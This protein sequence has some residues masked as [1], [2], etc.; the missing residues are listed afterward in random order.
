MTILA[1]CPQCR[2]T[3]DHLQIEKVDSHLGYSGKIVEATVFC[4]P[5]CHVI[6]GVAGSSAASDDRGQRGP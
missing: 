4:C 3:P 6:L 1:Q 5:H 2:K